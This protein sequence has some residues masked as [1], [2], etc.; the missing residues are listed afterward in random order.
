MERL[1]NKDFP[2]ETTG[3]VLEDAYVPHAKRLWELENDIEAGRLVRVPC[4]VGDTVY[5]VS[6]CDDVIMRYDNAYLKRT[7][8][9]ECPFE[10]QCKFEDCN[11]TEL[12]VFEATVRAYWFENDLPGGYEVWVENLDCTFCDKDFGRK[13]FLSNAEAEQA[14][15]A[16]EK[17]AAHE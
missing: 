10:N 15:H 11:A 7:G 1:T 4:K 9:S 13:I 12:Q 16:A 14:A 2:P 17:E 8:S 6:S 5:V 3:D